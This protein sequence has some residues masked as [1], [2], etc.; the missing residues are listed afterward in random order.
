MNNCPIPNARQLR[1]RLTRLANELEHLSSR[2][3]PVLRDN[4]AEIWEPSTS[5]FMKPRFWISRSQAAVTEL[6]SLSPDTRQKSLE[7]S[8]NPMWILIASKSSSNGNEVGWIKVWPSKCFIANI[9]S[10]DY[11]RFDKMSSEWTVSYD[12]KRLVDEKLICHI[13]LQLPDNA[14]LCIDQRARRNGGK[15]EFPVAIS[16]DLRQIT[17]LKHLV[18]IHRSPLGVPRQKFSV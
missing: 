6:D 7:P 17:L 10:E 11:H 1:E 15:F 4:H 12:I 3:G 16:H 8:L 18:R 9:G 14:I 2:W 13:E 5:A